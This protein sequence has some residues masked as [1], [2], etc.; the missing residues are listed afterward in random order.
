MTWLCPGR[1]CGREITG[2]WPQ[3]P[4]CSTERPPDAH[5]RDW[6]PPWVRDHVVVGDLGSAVRAMIE[7][8]PDP[9]PER[10]P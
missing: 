7:A 4:W 6:A 8:D 1:Y 10:Q 9:D 5:A 2:D 3:C